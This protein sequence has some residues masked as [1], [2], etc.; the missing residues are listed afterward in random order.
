MI[1]G[2]NFGTIENSSATAS[3]TLNV[4]YNDYSGSLAAGI[5]AIN[6][7]SGIVQN[8]TVNG[9]I[10]SIGTYTGPFAALNNGIITGCTHNGQMLP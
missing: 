2:T 10:Y 9:G 3:Y 4:V 8:C 1:A 5:T 7:S 6:A